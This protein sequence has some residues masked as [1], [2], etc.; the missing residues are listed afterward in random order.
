MYTDE[1][2]KFLKRYKGGTGGVR[3]YPQRPRPAI[4]QDRPLLQC[5]PFLV[6]S[7]HA[8]AHSTKVECTLSRA[9]HCCCCVS[10]QGKR[11]QSMAAVPNWPLKVRCMVI[12]RAF[13]NAL[14]CY[15]SSPTPLVPGRR[16]L[17]NNAR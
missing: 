8:G 5:N 9:W 13:H 2:V 4:A 11:R 7:S 14:S 12:T 10:I 6:G 16:M 3:V 17:R 1:V 15:I